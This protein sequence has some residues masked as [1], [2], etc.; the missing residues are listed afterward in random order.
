MPRLIDVD[1]DRLLPIPDA[2]VVPVTGW[3]RRPDPKGPTGVPATHSKPAI[4]SA[5]RI[6]I[7]RANL[8]SALTRALAV[9]FAA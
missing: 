2:Q 6:P 1:V 9:G 4:G 5:L 7:R 3:Q 8:G